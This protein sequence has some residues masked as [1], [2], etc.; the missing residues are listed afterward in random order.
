MLF[1]FECRWEGLKTFKSIERSP[2][3]CGNDQTTRGFT[4]SYKNLHFYWILG[5][6]HFVSPIQFTSANSSDIMS[7][8]VS[9]VNVI[10][11]CSLLTA[12]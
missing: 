1:V 9:N 4:K 10:S 7:L 8:F 5:A 12:L 2:M 11:H 6:G 3:Y